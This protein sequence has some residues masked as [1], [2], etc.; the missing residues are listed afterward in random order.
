[1]FYRLYLEG[2]VG[3]GG[4]IVAVSSV[5]AER[6]AKVNAHYAAAKAALES[7]ARTV[8]D[9]DLA[10]QSKWR[11]EVIRFDLV[12]TD[13]LK[14]LPAETLIGRKVISAETAALRILTV[15][16]GDLT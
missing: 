7:Y 1:M 13:M 6:P 8:A 16:G 11:V 14:A 15:M 12:D 2:V 5:A 10:K 4:V 3:D 9:S